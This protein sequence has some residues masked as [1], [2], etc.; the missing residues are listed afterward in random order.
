MI[1][2]K[3]LREQSCS[4]LL[5]FFRMHAIGRLLGVPPLLPLSSDALHIKEKVCFLEWVYREL[6]E[7]RHGEQ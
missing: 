7:L 4:L 3:P 2:R 6:Y 1:H 5:Y